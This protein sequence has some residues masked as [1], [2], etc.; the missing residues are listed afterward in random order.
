MQAISGSISAE[1]ANILNDPASVIQLLSNSLPSQSSYFIQV[2]LAQTFFL[3]S[4]VI[5]RVLP[6]TLALL[7]CCFGP[8]LTA[9]ER[10]LK[11]GILSSLEDPPEASLAETFAQLILLYM[12]SFVYGAIAPVTSFFLFFCFILIESGYRYQIIHNYP[13]G[14]DSG[15]RIWKHFIGFIL[16]A[17]I[18]SQLTLIGL[19]ALKQSRYAGPALGPLL[20]VTCLFTMFLNAQHSTVSEYLPTR[21]C[22]LKD[23]EN[24]AEGVLDMD[25]VK[26]AYLQPS[27][28]DELV[29]PDYEDDDDDE[30]GDD[31]TDR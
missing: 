10:S 11:W 27:L 5:L 31:S 14:Y 28:Q 30:E 1:L 21:D 16:V 17:M 19:L 9:K 25:F 13:R 2:A 20:A 15:G 8:R 12:V 24:T 18:V 29:K 22:I 6:L 4:M 7:R 26:G 23:S 3:Q